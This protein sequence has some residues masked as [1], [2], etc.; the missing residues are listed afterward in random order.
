MADNWFTVA[1]RS[2]AGPSSKRTVVAPSEA[3]T[4]PAEVICALFGAASARELPATMRISPGATG[5]A[6]WLAAFD[7][8]V[9][10]GAGT[11]VPGTTT[12]PPPVDN[13]TAPPLGSDAIAFV[14]ASGYTPGEAPWIISTASVA[15]TPSM[16]AF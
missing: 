11:P 3:A 7:T 14:N 13:G 9:I 15:S 1:Y 5:P 2:G 16:S 4:N 12:P 8:V 6:A 10:A